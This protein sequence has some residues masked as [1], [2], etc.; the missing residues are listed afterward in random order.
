MSSIE[1]DSTPRT[2]T[3]LIEEVLRKHGIQ[4]VREQTE[5]LAKR[6]SSLGVR[7]TLEI[8]DC[9]LDP[10]CLRFRPESRATVERAFEEVFGVGSLV[11]A[12]IAEEL[13]RQGLDKLISV[14]AVYESYRELELLLQELRKEGLIKSR[15]YRQTLIR[16]AI[17]DAVLRLAKPNELADVMDFLEDFLGWD[18]ALKLLTEIRGLQHYLYNPR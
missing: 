16:A 7:S 13:R 1:D 6:L 8:L 4:F 14:D 5:E 11:R 15:A 3:D 17:A 10:G 9:V 2:L 12:Q 18:R